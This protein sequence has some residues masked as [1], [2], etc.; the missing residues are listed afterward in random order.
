MLVLVAELDSQR[1]HHPGDVASAE[2]GMAA[3]QCDQ[4][5]DRIRRVARRLADLTRPVLVDPVDDGEGQVLLVAELVVQ[6]TSGVAGLPG[7]LFQPKVPIAVAGE[8]TRGRLEQGAARAGAALGLRC[9]YMHVCMLASRPEV[10]GMNAALIAAGCIYVL[11]A[12]IHGGA[13]EALVVRSLSA[14]TLPA[15]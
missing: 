2:H 8:A 9:T 6:S 3:R 15:T 7:H 11:A 5:G 1:H 10:F 13:G 14:D 12:A 4:L